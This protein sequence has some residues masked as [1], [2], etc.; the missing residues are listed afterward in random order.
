MASSF[1]LNLFFSYYNLNYLFVKNRHKKAM[2][3]CCKIQQTT[4]TA[5]YNIGAH[6]KK[7]RKKKKK[8]LKPNRKTKPAAEPV[9][10]L[11][12]L[13][14]SVFGRSTKMDRKKTILTKNVDLVRAARNFFLLL[15][16]HLIFF[17][18]ITSKMFTATRKKKN[19]CNFQQNLVFSNLLRK[20]HH[21]LT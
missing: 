20:T 10:V 21:Y 11:L 4:T 16:L 14:K 9:D 13:F 3:C 12:L 2:T 18:N 19:F 8:G 17:S 15:P 5:A 6:E 1:I 7:K